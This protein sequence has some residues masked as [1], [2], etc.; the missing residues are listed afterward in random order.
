MGVT[1]I[2]RL[3]GRCAREW[4][5]QMY[6]IEPSAAQVGIKQLGHSAS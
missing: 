1:V 4:D 2:V 5:Q 6:L 3:C